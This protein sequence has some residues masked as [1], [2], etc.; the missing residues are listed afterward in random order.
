MLVDTLATGR[1]KPASRRVACPAGQMRS[2]LP[3]TVTG[4]SRPGS[5]AS[6]SMLYPHSPTIREFSHSRARYRLAKSLI[7]DLSIYV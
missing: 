3:I 4:G 6:R 5:E 2:N 1:I 7:W